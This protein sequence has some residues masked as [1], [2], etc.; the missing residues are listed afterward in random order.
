MTIGEAGIVPFILLVYTYVLMLIKSMKYVKYQI[1]KPFVAIT[2]LAILMVMHNYF[3]NEF[4]LFISI[5][6]FVHLDQYQTK[7]ELEIEIQPNQI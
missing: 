3:N 1:Y 7:E 2:L 6:L 4:I 5:W